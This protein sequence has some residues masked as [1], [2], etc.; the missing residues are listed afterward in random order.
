MS[1]LQSSMPKGLKEEMSS[2]SWDKEGYTAWM[3]ELESRFG[4]TNHLLMTYRKNLQNLSPPKDVLSSF[5]TCVAFMLS[6]FAIQLV[7][8][9]A[10][11]F[12]IFY[13]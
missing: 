9:L 7:E 10:Y 13:T 11:F 8:F 12:Y 2:Y 3:T 5:A 4:N 1:Y 6:Y